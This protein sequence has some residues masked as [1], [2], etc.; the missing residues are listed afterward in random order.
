VLAGRPAQ[1]CKDNV[2]VPGPCGVAGV[3]AEWLN[4]EFIGGEVVEAQAR[5]DTRFDNAPAAA[6]VAQGVWVDQRRPEA[7][8][9]D[10]DDADGPLAIPRIGFIYR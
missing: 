9:P 10:F 2:G 6:M 3:D 7:M 8:V 4:V 1:W 5:R